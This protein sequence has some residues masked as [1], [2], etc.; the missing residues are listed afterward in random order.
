MRKII[1][2]DFFPLLIVVILSLFLYGWKITKWQY[3]SYD[4]SRD[5]LIIKR[6]LI[7]RKFTLI[8]PSIGIADGAYLPPFYYYFLA[9]S[10]LIS[11][12]HLWGPD[13]FS[14]ILGIFSVT[15]FYLIAKDFFGRT[16]AF[17]GSLFF[18]FNPYLIQAARH[19]RDPHMLPL[20]LL[21]FFCFFKKYFFEKKR[22]F[23]LLVSV[24]LGIAISLHLTAVVFFPFLVFLLLKDFRKF[25][26]NRILILSKFSF[27]FFFLPLL[28]FDLRHNFSLSKAFFSFFTKP[29]NGLLFVLLISKIERFFVL[30]FKLPIIFFSGTFQKELLSLRSMPLFPLEKIN[31]GILTGFD[32][33]KFIVAGALWLSVLVATL[34]L[35]KRGKQK[36]IDLILAFVFCGFLISFMCPI[37]YTFLYYF[38]GLFPFIFLLLTGVISFLIKKVSLSIKHFLIFTFILLA[39]LPF[40]P[41]M[42]KTETRPEKYFLPVTE[43]I[44][45]DFQRGQKMAVVSH[46]GDPLRWEYNGLEYR[47]FLES[48][49]R[50][51]L[52]GWEAS[53]YEKAEILYFVDEDNLPDPLSFKG[54]EM[55]AFAP[56]KILKTWEVSSGQKVYKMVK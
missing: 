8:G 23:L 1:K 41:N 18:A 9:P 31:V 37:N 33:L 22:W 43:I 19:T 52:T 51:P 42:F 27:I 11:K 24:S 14:A 34:Y 40:F 21:L 6:I 44:A 10:L 56:K 45:T 4:E 49:Y 2:C 54:M 5:Y 35:V 29:K 32:L 28:F 26:I 46:S 39:L 38:Y 16:P 48:I 55:E 36:F 3:F 15:L 13:I 30:L 17:I 12:F 20:F 53:D 50:L 47:Y 25:K 7:D